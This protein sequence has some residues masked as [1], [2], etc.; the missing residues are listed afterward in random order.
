MAV[1]ASYIQFQ[2]LTTTAITIQAP[3]VF[4]SFLNA[5]F[6]Q[7]QC[8]LQ[9]IRSVLF[10]VLLLGSFSFLPFGLFCLSWSVHFACDGAYF[11]RL[12]KISFVGFNSVDD[13]AC[14]FSLVG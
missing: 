5:P 14:G 3:P 2:S 8:T 1:L 10:W 12:V 6:A 11:D 13:Y 9:F 7:I 4:M